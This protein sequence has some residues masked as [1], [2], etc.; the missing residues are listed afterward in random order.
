MTKRKG[1]TVQRGA[2]WKSSLDNLTPR[3]MLLPAVAAIMLVSVYP[4][5]KTMWMSFYDKQLLKKTEIFNG[6]SNYTHALKDPE[7]WQVICNTLFFALVS[8]IAGVALAMFIGVKLIKPYPGKGFFRA[9]FL[10][11][12]VTPPLVASFVWRTILSTNFSPINSI[13]LKLG[14]VDTPLSFLEST[15]TYFG[16]LSIPLVMITIINVWSIFPFLMV[17]FIA[18]LQTVPK[19]LYEAATMDGAGKMKSFWKITVPCIR[20]IISVSVLL[21]LIWQFNNFN[22]SYMVTQGGPLGLTKLLAVEIYQQAFTNFNYGY[23]SSVSVIM[24]CIAFIPAI[25]YIRSSMKD[26]Q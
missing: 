3:L 7:I 26:L 14:I 1:K 20:P 2:S 9:L 13:L 24:M 11:P 23:A 8:L 21:E 19:E 10:I 15:Q 22:I 16:F 25:I 4:T 12:W 17:M 6:I 18:G 5:L